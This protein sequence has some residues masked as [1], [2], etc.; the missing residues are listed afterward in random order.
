MKKSVG[1]FIE[2]IAAIVGI[3]SVVLYGSSLVTTQSAYIFLIAAVVVALVGAFGAQ[4]MPICNWAAPVAAALAAAGIGWSVTVMADPIGY[5]ISGLYS[6]DDI[7]SWITF[8][9]V[10]GIAWLLYVI[11]GFAGMSK[12]VKETAEETEA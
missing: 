9:V 12:E 5:V 2:I 10:A 4:K 7:K 6:M 1:F 11:A 3:V 8:V